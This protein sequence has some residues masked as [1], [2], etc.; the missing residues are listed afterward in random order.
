M[1]QVMNI[2]TG[3][4]IASMPTQSILSSV[5]IPVCWRGDTLYVKIVPKP[6]G[7]FYS[8]DSDEEEDVYE[9]SLAKWN[10]LSNQLT[11]IPSVQVRP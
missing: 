11:N 2:V 4:M 9:V 8:S 1:I 10:Y 6:V 3:E 5:Q 7:G